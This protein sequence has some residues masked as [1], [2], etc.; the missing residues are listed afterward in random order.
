M[1]VTTPSGEDPTKAIQAEVKELGKKI[2]RE[3]MTVWNTESQKRIMEA[4]GA[5]SEID[6][7][8]DARG[9][10][11]GR[12]SNA[13]NEIAQEF[14]APVWN[15]GENAWIFS[16]THEAA[17]FHE[18][19]A[20]PH[21]I[22]AKAAHALAFEWPD[23]PEEVQEKFEDTFPLVFFDNVDHP[24]VPA[25]G[26]MRFG[27]EKARQRLDKAGFDASTFEEDIV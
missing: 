13:L 12:E 23:A 15:E 10:L 26:F 4:A 6:A 24:G 19:G 17:V 2:T 11:K 8:R 5:R 21:E 14:T 18:W 7:A 25:I 9:A 27:R 20:T 3:A 1:T 16:V 22:R